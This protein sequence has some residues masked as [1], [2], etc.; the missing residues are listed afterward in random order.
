MK[1]KIGDVAKCQKG[2]IG[3]IESG[4]DKNGVWHGRQLLRSFKR[5]QSK[6][7]TIVQIGHKTNE[8]SL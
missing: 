1:P 7:P 8:N 6:H 3:I 2:I 5:W 4:P